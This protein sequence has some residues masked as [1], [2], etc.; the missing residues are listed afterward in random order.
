[1]AIRP[2][3]HDKKLFDEVVA[4]VYKALPEV[5]G[6]KVDKLMLADRTSQDW[7]GWAADLAHVAR[8]LW[9]EVW[10]DRY[11]GDDDDRF[12]SV[13]LSSSSTTKMLGVARDSRLP[14]APAQGTRQRRNGWSL[15]AGRAML[16]QW[17]VDDWNSY[18]WFGR[19]SATGHAGHGVE[20]ISRSLIA[21]IRTLVK[22]LPER[23]GQ[24]ETAADE[25]PFVMSDPGTRA[26]IT[27][28]VGQAKF[29]EQVMKRFGRV[30][31][32][33]GCDV[34]Q[35]LEAAHILPWAKSREHDVGAALLLRSDLH[36]LFDLGQLNIVQRRGKARL[37]LGLAVRNSAPYADLEE[38][39]VGAQYLKDSQ[40]L[41]LKRRQ[42]V[43]KR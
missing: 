28:R 4:R 22:A 23:N 24:G 20:R 38:E 17:F 3:Q 10:Y 36:T 35:V 6:A 2:D 29:R 37:Q 19:Y 1:M 8:N 21:D 16:G 40:W 14:L 25:P 12:F 34:E 15:K 32:V 43:G 31:V 18:S 27:R 39:L 9:L 5:T 42:L 41:A 13:W 11:L 26:T 33:S 30:C 7:H